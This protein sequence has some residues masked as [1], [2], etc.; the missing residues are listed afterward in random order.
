MKRPIPS[1]YSKDI[2]PFYPDIP[3]K[4]L[5]NVNSDSI[6]V[7]IVEAPLQGEVGG[8]LSIPLLEILS[9]PLLFGPN[10]QYPV[11]SCVLHLY[12]ATVRLFVFYIPYLVNSPPPPNIPYTSN[13]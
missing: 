10:I 9:I 6:A 5:A 13:F 2:S 12:N 1:Q 3:Q 4:A 11:N 8:V 7:L